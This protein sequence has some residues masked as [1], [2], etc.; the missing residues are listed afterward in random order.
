VL[1]VHDALVDR[2]VGEGVEQPWDIHAQRAVIASQHGQ[3]IPMRSLRTPSQPAATKGALPGMNAAGMRDPA[4][5]AE[6][7]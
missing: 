5:R 4:L 7:R 2:R 3:A 6:G 1:A